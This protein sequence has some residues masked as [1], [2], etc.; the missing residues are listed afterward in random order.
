[1]KAPLFLKNKWLYISIC[2]I[3]LLI[4]IGFEFAFHSLDGYTRHGE[5][6][7]VPDLTG[8]SYEE[9]QTEYSDIFHFQLIDSVYVRD[10]PEGAV[11]QQN[12]KPGSK[13][14]KGRNMYII[15]TS[16]APE[17]VRIPNLRNLSLRQAMVSLNSVGLKVEKLVFVD[18]FARNAVVE[19]FVKDSVVEP[20]TELVKGTGVTL[21][22]G[23]G[24]GDKTTYLPDIVGVAQSVVRERVN[25]ASLNI[26]AEIFLDKDESENM[27]V[28][29]TEPEFD[30]NTMVKLG[31]EVNVWYRSVKTFDLNWYKLE[32]YRRDS[33]VESLRMRKADPEEIK[34]V[35]DSFN[36]I[37][38]HRSFS[39]DSAQRAKDMEMMFEYFDDLDDLY[40][41]DNE[42]DNNYFYD[43]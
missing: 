7:V 34:Y 37:L 18:Y 41:D 38:S 32:K 29:K 8:M 30:P 14:K 33:I 28:F 40:F 1:M 10:F 39:F 5:E 6:M 27:I 24:T 4:I 13:V 20:N 12:P 31:S 42:E 25:N 2:L 19:Q 36:Y 26:G 15:M 9:V 11:Y 16:V 3:I 35:L 23:L 17:I 43:E 22:V 21:H